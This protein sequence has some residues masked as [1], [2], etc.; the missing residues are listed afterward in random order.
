[1]NPVGTRSRAS[2]LTGRSA[3]P[4]SWREATPT[5]LSALLWVPL[6]LCLAGCQTNSPSQYVSPRVT[7]RVLDAQTHQPVADVQVSRVSA[8]EDLRALDVPKGGQAMETAP[9]VR[10]GADG[11]FVLDSE[12]SLTFF[13]RSG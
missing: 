1:M 5:M 6:A 8:N 7:G 13:R 4:G 2:G 10:T 12:R 9:A 11:T 3:A